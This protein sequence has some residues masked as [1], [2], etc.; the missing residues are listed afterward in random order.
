MTR[1]LRLATRSSKLALT[2]ARA[3]ARELIAIEPGLQIEELHVVTSGDRFQDR[4]LQDL[5][6]KGLFVKEI[7]QALLD[8][9]ADFAVHS[10]KDVPAELAPGLALGCIPRREDPRD[11]L[12]SQTGVGLGAL[13]A[14]SVVGTSSLRRRT[15]LLAV[16]PDLSVV[17][18]R[19]N[20][21]TRL[22]KVR[23][24]TVQA[25]ILALAGL[26]RMGLASEA[27]EI[28]DPSALVPAVGQGALGI[29]C[30]ADDRSIAALLG[31]LE[32]GPTRLAVAAERAFLSAV[33]GSC[34]LPVAAYAVRDGDE[35]WLRAMVAE[36]DGS[37]LRRG[38]CRVRWPD[39]SAEAEEVG[40]TIGLELRAQ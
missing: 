23:E 1:T 27:S 35:L 13:P 6:G 16:R 26:R 3:F 25:T 39:A 20:V 24:G 9:H 36:E 2:Q 40:R 17:P 34:R 18:L 4:P 31:R 21:D 11:A 10:M 19:G 30:R 22:R 8:D 33:E 5:G 37:R 28:L 38:E 15:M 7:E 29:E 12:V 14:G 32:D